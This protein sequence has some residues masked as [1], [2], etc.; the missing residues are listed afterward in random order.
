M[1]YQFA[2]GLK[3]WAV[4]LGAALSLM[5]TGPAM[6]S[7]AGGTIIRDTEIETYLHN[8]TEGVIHA[9][10][11]N[12]EQI[13]IVLVQSPEVNA[14]VA[15]GANIFINTGLIGLTDNVGQVVGVVA[16]EL[17]HIE[18]GHLTRTAEMGKNASFEAM[19]ATLL[20]V[21]AAV[22][23]GDSSMAAAGA[24]I[25][26]GQAMNRFLA[27]SRV[28]ES[29]ADQAG[30]RFMTGAGLSPEGLPSFLEKLSSQELLPVSQ[31]SEFV[32]T[33][34]LSRD[35]VEALQHK[36]DES[37]LRIK[38][39]S[40]Q[41]DGQYARV[42]AKILGFVSPQ[43]VT[44][45]FETKDKSIPAQYARAIAAYRMNQVD[46]ALRRMDALIVSEPQNP[47]FQELKGQMLYEF[48]KIPQSIPYFQRALDKMPD[49]G[50]V[51][52][53]LAQA[54]IEKANPTPQD[55]TSAIDHLKRAEKD[56]PRLMS[57][58]RLLAT[59]LGRRGQEAEARV[60]LAEEALMRGRGREAAKMAKASLET[61]SPSSSE[62]IRAKDII[63]TVGEPDENR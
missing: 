14:Y 35:R 49:A 1:A 53:A 31:Q 37:P 32:R 2:R 21:G 50:L 62:Y 56:E 5:G 25:G 27:Y 22:V 51:R 34:P 24:A 52:A 13:N 47:Y 38:P 59:A 48:G 40:T 17:G 36:V 11:M 12:P 23:S 42:K 61:L 15:G 41:W 20:G 54:L 44:Y 26:Q 18:G 6:A 3:V 60:Y 33:H 4:C 39:L 45:S 46:D 43:Q 19:L 7:S 63:N 9:A 55:L 16:H 29:S 8:W 28:Q 57:I 58:K 30:F 10:G